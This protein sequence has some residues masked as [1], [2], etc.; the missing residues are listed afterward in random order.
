MHLHPPSAITWGVILLSLRHPFSDPSYSASSH[1]LHAAASLSHS[2]GEHGAG[3]KTPSPSPTCCRESLAF[4]LFSP[5]DPHSLNPL[6]VTLMPQ[7]HSFSSGTSCKGDTSLL[8]QL[9]FAACLCDLFLFAAIT[10]PTYPP[11]PP[12][13]WARQYCADVFSSVI[14]VGHAERTDQD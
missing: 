7:E 9:V 1:V 13:P 8:Y 10:F 11:A 12:R 4:S 3:E 5:Q 14:A 6:S 2:Q